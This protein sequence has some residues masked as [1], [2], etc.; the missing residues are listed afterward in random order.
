VVAS[1]IPVSGFAGAEAQAE[2]DGAL[3]YGV[4]DVGRG[5]IVY[6]PNNPLFRGFWQGGK[7][8]FANAVFFVGVD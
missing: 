5:A 6:L 7:R 1:G 3:L 4:E 2:L 8:L